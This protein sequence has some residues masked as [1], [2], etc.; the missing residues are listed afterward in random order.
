MPKK[1]TDCVKKLKQQGKPEDS[2]WPICTESTGLKPHKKSKLS[3]VADGN[4]SV[5]GKDGLGLGS[6]KGKNKEKGC[7]KASEADINPYADDKCDEVEKKV[8]KAKDLITGGIADTN[9]PSDFNKKQLE[10][11]IKVE[12]EHTNSVKEAEEVALDHLYE[13]PNYYDKLAKMEND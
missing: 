13:M 2:A 12:M 4:G 10:M 5:R 8:K 11:G 1:L 3:G 7:I 9:K 6:G